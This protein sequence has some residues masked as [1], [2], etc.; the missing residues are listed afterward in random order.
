MSLLESEKGTVGGS[1]ADSTI[2]GA[3]ESFG[4]EGLFKAITTRGHVTSGIAGTSAVDD[5]GSFDAI[6]S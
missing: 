6:L 3:G 1:V 2:N 4:T 5:L